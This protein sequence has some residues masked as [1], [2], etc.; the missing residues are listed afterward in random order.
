MLLFLGYKKNPDKQNKLCFPLRGFRPGA[1]EQMAKKYLTIPPVLE[2]LEF[3]APAVPVHDRIGSHFLTAFAVG[4][5]TTAFTASANPCRRDAHH[6]GV[7]R[8]WVG[9][10]ET[11]LITTWHDEP[12]IEVTEK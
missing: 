6:V 11:T 7:F 10:E 5:P 9:K 2:G 4:R 12:P 8:W 1:P 3:A